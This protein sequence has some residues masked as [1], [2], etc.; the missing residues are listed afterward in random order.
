[1]RYPKLFVT[2]GVPG[3][4]KTTV[5]RDLVNQCIEGFKVTRLNRDDFRRMMHGRRFGEGRQEQ[6]V[7]AAQHAAILAVLSEGSD[8]IVDD[9][10]LRDSQVRTFERL[11]DAAG[12]EVVIIDLRD[13]PLAECIRRDSLREGDRRIGADEIRRL[14]ADHVAKVNPSTRAVSAAR[15]ARVTV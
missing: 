14:H 10:N 9:T 15:R 5:A 3:S 11:A 6:L 12:A 1:M 8:V 2:R 7:T 13:V 4:G